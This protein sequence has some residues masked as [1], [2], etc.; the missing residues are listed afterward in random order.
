MRDLLIMLD[1]HFVVVRSRCRWALWSRCQVEIREDL[2]FLPGKFNVRHVMTFGNFP[3]HARPRITT[4]RS[5]LFCS[6]GS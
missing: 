3:P 2:E 5:R 1:R 4:T 6:L